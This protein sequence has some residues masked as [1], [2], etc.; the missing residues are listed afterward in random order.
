M[1]ADVLE[2]RHVDWDAG[3]L[4]PGDGGH[5]T[6]PEKGGAERLV[7]MPQDEGQEG[8]QEAPERLGV[9]GAVVEDRALL[10]LGPRVLV[11]DQVAHLRLLLRADRRQPEVVEGVEEPTA[12]AFGRSVLSGLE[13]HVEVED[14]RRHRP[15][16]SDEA[17]KF[18]AGVEGD[19]ERVGTDVEGRAGQCEQLVP[20]QPQ[21]PAGPKFPAHHADRPGPIAGWRLELEVDCPDLTVGQSIEV[22]G[23]IGGPHTDRRPSRILIKGCR[24]LSTMRSSPKASRTSRLGSSSSCGQYRLRHGVEITGLVNPVVTLGAGGDDPNPLGLRLPD[25]LAQADVPAVA[26]LVQERHRDEE[27]AAKALHHEAQLRPAEEALER[28]VADHLLP[29]EVV[30]LD[31]RAGLRLQD[32]RADCQLGVNWTKVC[33]SGR[34]TSIV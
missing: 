6:A 20:P 27:I 9:A 7:A 33:L 21:F 14:A 17:S 30:T 31:A 24:A 28:P 25:R 1:R 16:E 12:A 13:F 26:L 22:V 23:G 5:E 10:G 4:H 32:R 2:Q 19:E 29:N 18:R 15:A 34:P 11:H 8:R 3:P